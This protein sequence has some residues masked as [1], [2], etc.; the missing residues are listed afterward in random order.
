MGKLSP[1]QAAKN[2]ERQ[3]KWRERAFNDPD[4]HLLHRVNLAL[5]SHAAASLRRL[6]AGYG[7]THRDLIERLLI[8]ANAAVAET[9]G[10]ERR[11]AYS[12]GRLEMGALGAF[13]LVV[14]REPERETLQPNEPP[15]LALEPCPPARTDADLI[16]ILKASGL[17]LRDIQARTAIN[18]ADVS[19]IAHG[20]RHIPED[21]R[22]AVLALVAALERE[23]RAE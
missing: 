7:L 6:S 10:S 15:P 3:R 12:D 1:E 16:A 17:S 23:A 8:A 2:R 11:A 5:G 14:H 19:R 18:F 13:D 22:A 4:G 9:I 21:K 20:K